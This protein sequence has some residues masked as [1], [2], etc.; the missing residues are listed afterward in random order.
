M[1]PTARVRGRRPGTG[2]KAGLGG[3]GS[4]E[5]SDGPHSPDLPHTMRRALEGFTEVYIS[6]RMAE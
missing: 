4:A 1:F 6:D 2:V 5:Y 3:G